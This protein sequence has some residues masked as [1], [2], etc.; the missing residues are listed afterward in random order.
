MSAHRLEKFKGIIVAMNS[1]Y[2][3]DGEISKPAVQRLARHYADIGVKGLYLS[4]ST[5]EGMLQSV[6][7]R[8]QTLE[9][10]M[11]E[12]GGQL[13]VIAHVGAASTRDSVELA[14]HAE[15]LHVCAVSAVPSVYYR[16]SEA[17]VEHHWQSIIDRTSLPF[18]IYHIP[19]L[20]GFHLSASLLKRMASQDKVIG[21]K[22]SSESTFE[23][24]QFKAAGGPDFLVFNGPD[25][26]YLAGRS[27]GADG[28]IGGT[29]GIMPELF[30][31]IEQC[32][33]AGRIPEVQEWQSKV[34]EI[35]VALLS[36]PSLYGACKAILKLRGIDC[37]EPRL[38]LLPLP[39][40]DLARLT[41]L[42]ERI[43]QFIEQSKR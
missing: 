35:I 10:A 17:A 39:G 2:G 40:S 18:I 9:A 15:A 27:I 29:Y 42:N 26:Q 13:T 11:E 19:A 16:L 22:I 5:G 28:G 43:L 25:E 20:T 3:E 4:G 38:P 31:K 23:L 14:V 6:D 36:F 34:N 41:A 24:Q 21:V 7:E 12:V 37:G 30:M 33:V 1:C 32:F 8:K